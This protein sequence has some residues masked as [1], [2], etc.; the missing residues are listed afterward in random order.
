MELTFQMLPTQA[1]CLKLYYK[2]G[3]VNMMVAHEKQLELP[4]E[5]LLAHSSF[6]S[7]SDILEFASSAEETN[8]LVVLRTCEA[9]M[10]RFSGTIAWQH[11]LL[12]SKL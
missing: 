1:D 2:Y 4:F 12:N 7:A 9:F 5:S 11:S 6:E 3:M 10:A 8:C